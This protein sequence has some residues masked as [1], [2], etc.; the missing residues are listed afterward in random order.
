[1][2]EAMQLCRTS[3]GPVLLPC[4]RSRHGVSVK[5]MSVNVWGAVAL[6]PGD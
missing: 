6:S 1:M 2:A 3:C 4:G 5:L